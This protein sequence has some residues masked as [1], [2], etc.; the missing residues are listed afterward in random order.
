MTD[1]HPAS[2]D[3]SLWP[4]SRAPNLKCPRTERLI[5][6][7]VEWLTPAQ[8]VGQIIQADIASVS[9]D[10]VAKYH[11]GSVLNGGNSAPGRRQNTPLSDWLNLAD[12]FWEASMSADGPRIPILWGTDAVHGHNNIAGATIFPHNVNLGAA[13]DPDLVERIGAATAL[14]V[15]ASG[16]DWTF[17]PS[18]AVAQDIR[19]GRTYEAYS[20]CPQ[21]CADLGAALVRG[22]QGLPNQSEFLGPEKVIATA[23]HFLGDGGT[24]NGTD[25]GETIA[26]EAELRDVHARAYYSALE[27]GVQT[28]MASFSSW[29]GRKMHGHKPLLSDLLKAHLGFDGVI[30][31]DWNGHGQ[32]VGVTPTNCPDALMAGLDIYMAPDSWKELH[33]SLLRQLNSGEISMERLDDAVRRVLRL[34]FRAGIFSAPKPSARPGAAMGRRPTL[35]NH[36][37]LAAEAVQKSAVLLKNRH[38]TLPLN[39]VKHVLVVGEAADDLGTLCGGWTQ[40]WQGGRLQQSDY[41]HAETLLNG[42]RRVAKAA[43]GHV[44]YATGGEFS[45]RPDVAIFVFGESPYAEFRGDRKSLEYSA[46]DSRELEILRQLNQDGIPV[47]SVFISGRP[48]WTNPHLNASDAFIAGFL[49]GTQ[50]GALADLIFSNGV[51]DFTGK[52]PFAWPTDTNLHATR[53]GQKGSSFTF[54]WGYGLG[55]REPGD[56]PSLNEHSGLSTAD[57]QTVFQKGVTG[58]NWSIKLGKD[59]PAQAWTGGGRTSEDQSLTAKTTDVG[60]QENAINCTWHGFESCLSFYHLPLDLSRELNAGF[61][62]TLIA[63]RDSTNYESIRLLAFSGDRWSDIGPLGELMV[64]S[65]DETLIVFEILL[66]HLQKAGTDL[67]CLQA[68]AFSGRD[69]AQL[70]MLHL[71]VEMPRT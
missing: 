37:K 38:Q 58:P 62:F 55:L 20:E 53:D 71:A 70:T 3:L 30:I 60:Q 68:L 19:W 24:R 56:I 41:P 5:T 15:R 66:Q 32:I 29:G 40:S 22:L 49:P 12:E 35:A 36:A 14:D 13:R 48:L 65:D 23:K 34:K 26:T 9:P 39:P 4:L 54:P 25:Q 63:S 31:G 6:S 50:A 42:I 27:A 61:G 45:E 69:G 7:I 2:L 17:A 46:P 21:L 33:A 10:D 52:L 16:M 57:D 64:W 18:I 44:T 1:A 8:K 59:G 28:I 11:L 47:V 51:L 43:G 67:T